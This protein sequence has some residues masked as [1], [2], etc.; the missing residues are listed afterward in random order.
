VWL[1]S[2]L[3]NVPANLKSAL[4]QALDDVSDADRVLL[5]FGNCGNVIQGLTSGDF[6]LIIPRLDDCISLVMG[7]Q[8]RREAYSQAHRAMYQTD[9]WMDT[10]HNLIDE[11]ETTCEMYGEEDAEDVFRMMY[12][13]YETMAYLDT[14][15][16]DVDE[17]ME[18]TRFLTDLMELEQKVE[19]ATLA[20]VDLLVCGP[21]EEEL[22]VHVPPHGKVP[23]APFMQPGSVLA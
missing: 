5:G 19:P 9:G 20:Y 15:L 16:Y 12:A 8:K 1:E 11:Y 2:K 10:G 13:H 22:F 3:H 21:W 23:S 7:S 6:E 14:G 17:L 18:R 4:Q